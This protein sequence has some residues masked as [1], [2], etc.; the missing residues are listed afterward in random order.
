MGSRGDIQPFLGAAVALVAEGYEVTVLTNRDNESL[1]H[2]LNGV[3]YRG[4]FCNIANELHSKRALRAMADGDVF[5]FLRGLNE[6]LDE[7]ADECVRAWAEAIYELEP[8]LIL[9][10]TFCDFYMVLATYYY[11]IATVIVRLS[12]F[13]LEE[14]ANWNLPDLRLFGLNRYVMTAVLGQ[15][16]KGW[17]RQLNAAA[18]KVVGF[19]VCKW[20]PEHAFLEDIASSPISPTLVAMP[21]EWTDVLYPSRQPGYQSIGYL[22]LDPQIRSKTLFGDDE[23]VK[24]IDAFVGSSHDCVYMGWGSMTCR[25]AEYMAL[26]VVRALKLTGLRAI[27]VTGWSGMSE[28]TLR[29]THAPDALLE[30]AAK[31][32]LFTACAPHEWLFPRCACVVHHG[33]AGTTG[34]AL[35]AGVP[36]IIT[37]VFMDQFDSAY[38]VNKLALG[39]GFS[40]QLQRTHPEELANA[41]SRCVTNPTYKLNAAALAPKVKSQRAETALTKFIADFWH[42]QV[43]TGQYGARVESRLDNRRIELQ[44]SSTFPFDCLCGSEVDCVDKTNTTAAR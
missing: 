20:H 21:S 6:M 29:T 26:L 10:G 39:I 37:P 25:S 12:S 44:R 24:A 15:F 18:I 38:A 23:N 2:G 16:Y 9:S 11:K 31:N 28:A 40:T 42:S 33:G 27:V 3:Q 30:Y 32:V 5:S 34:A 8:D 13:E 19:D 22:L 17:Q 41:I 4:V 43:C 35:R 14:R 36:Q 7:N 1:V